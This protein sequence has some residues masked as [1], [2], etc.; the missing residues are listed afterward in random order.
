MPQA[1]L[2][3]IPPGATPIN[4]RISVVREDGQWTYFCGIQPVFQH[5]EDD[6]RSFRMFT[7][8]LCWQGACT[9]AQI[10][11]AFGVSKNSVLRSVAKYRR[12]GINGFY[13]PRRVRSCAVMTPKVTAEAERLL[14]LGYLRRE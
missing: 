6:R 3:M 4:D 12:E 1:L 10:I 5:P 13:R 9:Q 8:Q 11:H 7:A 2:P 14:G